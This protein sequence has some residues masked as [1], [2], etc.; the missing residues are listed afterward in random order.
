MKI[1]TTEKINAKGEGER[2]GEILSPSFVKCDCGLRN[3]PS[4]PSSLRIT[5]ANPP[6]GFVISEVYE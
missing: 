4:I 6:S 2:K 5:S 1:M 3:T